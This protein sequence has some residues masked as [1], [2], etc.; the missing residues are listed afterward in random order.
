M[1]G[2][3]AQLVFLRT[4]GRS[5]DKVSLLPPAL[6]RS[7]G[8]AL[9]VAAPTIASLRSIYKRAATAFDHQRWARAHLGFETTSKARLTDLQTIL[10]AQAGEVAAIDE[11][12]T[13]GANW[14]FERKILIPAE[15]T[16]RD[17][18][19]AA[20][21]GVERDAIQLIKTA[22]PF[23][24]RK[25]C[26][27]AVFE[28]RNGVTVLEWLRKPPRRHSP[29]T[30]DETLEKI[31]FL[32]DLQAHTWDLHRIPLA[33]QG[34]YARAIAG[35][36]P[37]DSRRRKDDTQLL[38]VIFFLRMTLLELT[39]SALFQT[40]RRISDFARQAAGKTQS[41]Q[42][43]RSGHYRESLV[44]IKDLI[45]DTTRTPEQRLTAIGE[46]VT[47]LGDLAPNSH[48]AVVRETLSDDPVRIHSL[49]SAV[50]DLQFRGRPKDSA[51]RQLEELRALH[52]AGVAA[53][54]NDFAVPVNKVWRG[55][56]EGPD[57]RRAFKALEACTALG[58]RRALRRGSVWV[59]HSLTFRERDQMLIPPDEWKRDK[60]R[61]LSALGLPEDPD[62]F[63]T[64]QL[65][66]IKAGL[67]SAAAAHRDGSVT[68]DAQ[69]MLRLPA[70]EPLPD[71]LEPKRVRDLLFREIGDV[72]FPDLILEVDALTNFSEILLGRRAQDEHELIALYAALIVHGTEIDAKSVAAMIPQLDPG[73]VSTAMRALESTGRLNRANQRVVEF[74]RQHSL[75][76]LWGSGALGSSDMMSIDASRNLWNARIDPRRRTYAVG[77]Y[78]HVLDH[79]GIV[80]NQPVVLNERQAG[81]AIEG[82]VRHNLQT[83]N[84][85]LTRLA[86]DTH[87]YTYAGMTF[88]KLSG[89]DL[90]PRLRDLAERKLYLPRGMDAPDG[91]GRVIISDVSLKAIR[92]GWD[93][94][95]SVTASIHSGRVSAPVML[96]RL[97]SAAKGD[98]IHRAADQLGRLLRTVFL[99]DYFSSPD[100]RREMHTV[101]NRGESIHQLQRTVHS[102]KLAPER[103]RR[104]DELFAI[105]GSHTLLTNMVVAWN[106][107]RMQAT[108]DRWRKS[109]RAV[110]DRW[111]AR[112]GP[113]HSSH[114]NFRGLFRFGIDRY[115]AVLLRLSGPAKR[116][117]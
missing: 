50:S 62:A 77:L 5:L 19:R 57:R 40:G 52:A 91:L 74:Q 32:K 112:M 117:A 61:H 20:F 106:T 22:V 26:R 1:V 55:L 87:G 12:V 27:K 79:H 116:S 60:A 85:R 18:C 29:S 105:S 104:R 21:A 30:L 24:Q 67:A 39:D 47:A 46:I 115:R 86:V 84:T 56:V 65:E 8:T 101:L 109:G 113:A 34:A 94:L 68:I 92:G 64:P 69:G 41:R 80:Y 90:C 107:H 54:P 6:L 53:L 114:I 95:L 13:A 100:F 81:A 9:G 97:G 23:D 42:A 99:C 38:E 66:L 75:T 43:E 110:E 31:R 51:L 3:A 14:L 28:L 83:E 17:L 71:E 25:T 48:A 4:T 73:H 44:S 15:R 49:L 72:Q 63:L 7:L 58:L 36:P 93:E 78:T 108:V 70:L 111:L 2:L 96:Q 37:S 45:E 102:G 89:F 35:R 10:A 16:L 98:P 76:R 103:G 11:L 59:D 82:A 88:A 33:R